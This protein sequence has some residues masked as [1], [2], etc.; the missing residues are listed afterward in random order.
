MR[1]DNAVRLVGPFEILDQ[2]EDLTVILRRSK[3]LRSKIDI[4]RSAVVDP[5]VCDVVQFSP[6]EV[7]DHRQGKGPRT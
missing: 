6:R 2:A 4:S 5:T 7:L 3:L 1:Q